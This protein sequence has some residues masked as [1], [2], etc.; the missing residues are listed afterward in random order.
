MFLEK[1][2]EVLIAAKQPVIDHIQ[3]VLLIPS[4]KV[5]LAPNPQS[6]TQWRLIGQPRIPPPHI[7]YNVVAFERSRVR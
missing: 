3:I 1:V 5:E 2:N 4:E 6:P 7:E